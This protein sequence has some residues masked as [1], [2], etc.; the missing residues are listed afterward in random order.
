ML[1]A[2]TNTFRFGAQMNP[3]IW[4]VTN[5]SML[6]PMPSWLYECRFFAIVWVYYC[7]SFRWLCRTAIFTNGFAAHL[8][9]KKALTIVISTWA[10]AFC[11]TTCGYWQDWRSH[12]K[13]PGNKPLS[14]P[15]NPVKR[16]FNGASLRKIQQNGVSETRTQW[17][18]PKSPDLATMPD[19]KHPRLA[20]N[21]NS[22]QALHKALQINNLQGF[23]F[24]HFEY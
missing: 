11:H 17:K 2:S 10:W 6:L 12:R 4:P 21:Q 20:K 14:K 3:L 23:H 8:W 15:F 5:V 16:S 19:I 24:R 1:L 9:N 13:K 18:S 22:G 7:V